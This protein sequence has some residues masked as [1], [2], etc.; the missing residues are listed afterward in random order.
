MDTRW[1]QSMLYVPAVFFVL[2]V[3][4]FCFALDEPF[5]CDNFV[6]SQVG[7]HPDCKLNTEAL[8]DRLASALSELHWLTASREESGEQDLPAL[9]DASLCKGRS[10]DFPA[11]A[12]DL[13]AKYTERAE[14]GYCETAAGMWGSC[15][16]IPAVKC[17]TF[18]AARL[19]G[20]R[21]WSRV[22]DWGSGC[23]H[24]LTD[25]S[26]NYRFK[27]VGFD[28]NR[29]GVEWARNA[30]TGNMF[31]FE[32]AQSSRLEAVPDDSVDVLISNAVL[33]H[34]TIPEACHFIK[35]HVVRVLRPGGCAWFGW[36]H[37]TETFNWTA[38]LFFAEYY[39]EPIDD[40][41]A[42]ID[43]VDE[44]KLFGMSEYVDPALPGFLDAA[45]SIF[46]CKKATDDSMSSRKEEI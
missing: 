9:I 32:D 39:S 15:N 34:L 29:G 28:S 4:P 14:S 21:S 8:P 25:L 11:E 1:T 16:P 36:Q 37:S 20:L 17:K 44:V 38:D 42:V 26:R 10:A 31:C 24:G 41:V 2:G 3:V 5:G 19:L 35:A 12:S 27:G 43:T 40:A 6:F 22:L 45:F 13:Q 30:D 33:Y 23:G 7:L 18:S 46:L